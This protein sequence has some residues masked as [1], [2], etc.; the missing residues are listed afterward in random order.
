MAKENH[1]GSCVWFAPLAADDAHHPGASALMMTPSPV[2]CDLAA[3]VV[4]AGA[5]MT[6]RRGPRRWGGVRGSSS[7]RP[8]AQPGKLECPA[9]SSLGQEQS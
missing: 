8:D 9:L 5:V 7:H 4:L 6:C 3:A 1:R 2:R